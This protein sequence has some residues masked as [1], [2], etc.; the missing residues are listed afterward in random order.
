M[1]QVVKKTVAATAPTN[2][3]AEENGHASDPLDLFRAHGLDL[4]APRPGSD[5]AVA[6]C[7]WCGKA[8]FFVGTANKGKHFAGG[9]ECKI[10]G[11][12][13]NGYTFL[14][15]LWKTSYDATN[16]NDYTKLA[17][18]RRLLRWETLR[19]WGACRS[20]I[21]GRWI[22]PGWNA[23]GSLVNLYRW[24]RTPKPGKPDAH[25]LLGTKG[26]ASAMFGVV[27]EFRNAR[28]RGVYVCEGPWDGMA[29]WEMLRSVKHLE[30]GRHG[31][32]GNLSSSL[33]ADVEVWAVPGANTFGESWSA[34]FEGAEWAALLYDSDHPR[35]VD[36]RRVDGAGIAG[37]RR[38]AQRVAVAETKPKEMR[39][40]QW[41]PDGFD[42]NRPTGTDVRDVLASDGADTITE[43]IPA[44]ELILNRIQPIPAEW[45]AGAKGKAAKGKMEV[46]AVACERWMDLNRQWRKAM[47]WSEGLD[48][49]LSVMLASLASTNSVGDQLW[50]QIMGPPS[51]GKSTLCEALSANSRHVVAKSTIRGFHSGFQTDRDAKEDYSLLA[52]LDGKTLIT[53]DGDTILQSPNKSQLLSEARD[54]Y[55]RVSR[56]SYRN[57]A[58]RDYVGVSMTW[59]LCGTSALRELD[60]SELGERFVKCCI[61]QKVD[62]DTERDIIR[63]VLYRQRDVKGTPIKEVEALSDPDTAR[64]IQMTAGYVD[65]L[66]K[67]A[68]SLLQKVNDTDEQLE[69]IGNLARFVSFLRARPSKRQ[70]ETVERELAARLASQLH[71]LAT[72][73][74]VVLNK[75]TLDAE[76]M[77]RTV[78]CALD[79]S[80]GRTLE[81]ARVLAAH[82]E[83]LTAKA[84]SL[85]TGQAEGS[86][87]HYLQHLRRLEA[88]ELFEAKVEGS[89]RVVA[90]WRL[91][92]DFGAL[93]RS[94]VAVGAASGADVENGHD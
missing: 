76:V 89:A 79:T 52:K 71:R 94:V 29:W 16:A 9:W 33:G 67:W 51:C 32:T 65:Y 24:E 6:E 49:A 30:G 47:Q 31:P 46:Q 28:R 43:R 19:A 12:S 75:T 5:Q 40:L 7:P 11:E 77:R 59:I 93:Y 74:A 63:K 3:H 54:V 68:N 10:C 86:E 53:K 84:V 56:T 41:G 4:P 55:D 88:V 57:S 2:G 35:E 38:V 8:K 26:L 72:C 13:G 58:S 39:Y 60:T 17:V 44:V 61:M 90:R 69:M 18:D 91:S 34:I 73:L 20:F 66:G 1:P 48:R 50:V 87:R 62:P 15:K 25:A 85:M 82:P 21:S 23:E 14:R 42:A 22:V 83:G 80:A 37:M 36:G 70:V 78:R 81:I 27:P 92:E 64:A 45:I